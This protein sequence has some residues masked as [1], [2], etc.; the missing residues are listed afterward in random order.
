M[1]LAPCKVGS[2]AMFLALCKAVSRV[3]FLLAPSEIGSRAMFLAACKVGSRPCFFLAP[4]NVGRLA[5]LCCLRRRTRSITLQ[6][7]LSFVA[8]T[9]SLRDSWVSF[10]SMSAQRSGGRPLGRSC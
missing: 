8:V 9:A 5:Y 3:M 6:D 1:F 4:C 2:W 10:S 7:V